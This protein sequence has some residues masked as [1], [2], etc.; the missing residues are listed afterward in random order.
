MNRILAFLLALV[1]VVASGLLHGLSA[2]RWGKNL[3]MMEAVGRVP[4]VPR[5]IG[6]WHAQDVPGDRDAFAMAGA[7]GWWVRTYTHPRHQEPL[8]VIL[9][10]GRSG[11][12]AVHT[13][14]VCYRGAG[15]DML[16]DPIAYVVRSDLG[17]G[18]G[19]FR[20]A[21][22]AKPVGSHKDLRL[23][24]AWKTTDEWLAPAS[25]RW[26]F[27]GQPYLYK[28]YISHESAGHN[29]RL[30]EDPAIDFLRQFLPAIRSC[31][32]ARESL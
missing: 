23:F 6:E 21:R 12:M 2:E 13:P 3:L 1:V 31:L 28:L 9:M 22:F 10:C 8:L 7:Q 30:G 27:G 5:T 25:P 15:Y 14:E 4:L 26:E 18:L 16:E 20:T 29:D 19:H 17:E 24:W 11:Q 32:S